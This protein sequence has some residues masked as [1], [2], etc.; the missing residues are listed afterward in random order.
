MNLL[1]KWL[2]IIW[3]IM[4]PLVIYLLI[5]GAIT[6]VNPNGKKE[7]NNPVIWVIIISI[8]L[9]IVIGFMIFGYYAI[10][11][12]YAHLPESSEEI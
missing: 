4:G 8:F 1:K 3:I 6:H 9:P 10:K 5:S 2:G 11:D 7:I 12:E